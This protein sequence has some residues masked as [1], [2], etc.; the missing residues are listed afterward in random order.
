MLMLRELRHALRRLLA[1]PGYAF[2]AVLTLALGIGAN[3]LVF[4]L[5]DGVYLRPLPYRDAD[6]LIDVYATQSISGGAPDSV[7]IPDYVDLHAGVPAFADSALYTD[8]SSNL[9]EGGAPER[10]HGLRATPSLFSTLGATAAL[11]RVFEADDAVPG[12]EHVAVL[13]DAL[14]RNHF[15]ADSRVLERQV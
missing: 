10:L 11:G 15:D 6:D 14:R 13:A 7:S 2:T 9:V 5:I 3:V 4:T 1:R 8:A 12:R